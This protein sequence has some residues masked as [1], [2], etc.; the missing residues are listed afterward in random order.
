MNRKESLCAVI[1]GCVGAVLTMILCSFLPLGAQSQSDTKFGKITCTELE[2]VDSDGTVA[3]I[4]A[5]GDGGGVDLRGKDGAGYVNL[6]IDEH[7]GTVA[8]GK[9][10][11]LRAVMGVDK[12]GAGI[13]MVG[14]DGDH[15]VGLGVD[16]YG[17]GDVSTWDKNGNHL[18]TLK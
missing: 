14:K 13:I 16:E 8:V 10:G 18:A 9:D 5:T 3:V 12:H 2:I 15:R 1:G 17:N 4:H 6:W 11:D 7:G